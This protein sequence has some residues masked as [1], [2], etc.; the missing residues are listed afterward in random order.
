M[1]K[2]NYSIYFSV[3]LFPCSQSWIIACSSSLASLSSKWLPSS[4]TL[5]LSSCDISVIGFNR[6]SK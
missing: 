6:F 5:F 2:K 4:F 3:S 1:K